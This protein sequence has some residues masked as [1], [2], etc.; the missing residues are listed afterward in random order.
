MNHVFIF[1]PLNSLN[2][3]HKDI[4]EM[5]N[6]FKPCLWN[7]SICLFLI[8]CANAVGK[9]N[10]TRSQDINSN[11]IWPNCPAIL[12][13]QT[14]CMYRPLGLAYLSYTISLTQC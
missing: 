12:P 7:S 4:F 10:G 5:S 11:V 9:L 6:T 13:V 14:Q 8:F 2:I 3:K 1:S